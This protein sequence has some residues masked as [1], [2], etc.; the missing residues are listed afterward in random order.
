MGP[1]RTGGAV[2]RRQ[3]RCWIPRVG[4]GW[5]PYS[6]GHWQYYPGYGY[7]F[8]SNDSWGWAPFHY[9]RWTY[10]NGYGWAWIT[11]ISVECMRWAYVIPSWLRGIRTVAAGRSG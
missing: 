1:A 8:I 9:G 4:S 5:S 3:E 7:T 11:T 6:N 2:G 10:L